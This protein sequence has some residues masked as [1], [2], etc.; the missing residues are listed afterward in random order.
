MSERLARLFRRVPRSRD[1]ARTPVQ[2]QD[3]PSLEIIQT[4]IPL[5]RPCGASERAFF[6]GSVMIW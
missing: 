2:Q 5:A 6:E 4:L 1:A 3:L